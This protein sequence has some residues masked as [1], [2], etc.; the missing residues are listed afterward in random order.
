MKLVKRN[1]SQ[2]TS[3]DQTPFN[4]LMDGFFDDFL[5]RDQSINSFYPS[6]DIAESEK[7]FEISLALPGV[8]KSDVTLEVKEDQLIIKGERKFK[9]EQKEKNY[10]RL[11]S[12]Y[13]VFE[14]VFNLPEGVDANE[15]KA[16]YE[17][18]ILQ[19]NLP[20]VKKEEFT[21][22]IKIS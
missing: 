9:E 21:K 4:C 14:K 2:A 11:E 20:K 16:S 7:G 12:G 3:Y 5:T 17:D 19:I 1:P 18:G 22:Q 13:G 10:H 15:V 8:K 6:T